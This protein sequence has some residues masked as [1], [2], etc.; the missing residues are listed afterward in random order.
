MTATRDTSAPAP[1]QKSEPA[2][3]KRTAAAFKSE[4]H[5]VV[6]ARRVG[7]RLQRAF[8]HEWLGRRFEEE[9]PNLLEPV[10]HPSVAE[11]GAAMP[12]YRGTNH[13]WLKE[14]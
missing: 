12:T 4:E 11:N 1:R 13:S 8:G 5:T 3:A 10:A 2:T 7:S 9:R 14:A 6:N